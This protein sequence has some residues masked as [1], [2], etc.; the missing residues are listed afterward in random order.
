MDVDK[1]EA[2]ERVVRTIRLDDEQIAKLLDTMDEP[3]GTPATERREAQRYRYRVKALLVHMQQPGSS[4][5][6]PYLVPTRNICESGL[7]FVHGGFV[8]DGTRCLAQL[9]TTYGTWDDV[10]GSV[11]SCGYV[12]ANIHEVSIRFDHHIDPSVYCAA[13]VNYRVLLVEDDPSIARLA[14]FHLVKLNAHVEHVENGKIAVDK[15]MKTAYDVILMDMGLPVMDGFEAVKKLRSEGYSGI[16]V[17]A[18]AL[19]QPGD[20]QRCLEAG[21]DK[22]IAKPF[23]RAD[24]DKLLQVLREEPLISTLY[25]D[26]SM[27]EMIDTYVQELPAKVRTIEQAMVKQ[28]A[29]GLASLVR[30]LKAEGSGYG[31]EIITETAAAIESA[32]ID[33]SSTTDVEE[34]IT[35]LLKLCR[36][37]RS[38]AR[39]TAK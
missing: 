34:D 14:T 35:K 10:W 15:A 9:I 30:T 16:I 37:A 1:A 20:E 31:F 33:G 38:S 4:I 2:T 39:P 7:S 13:A 26:S 24:L 28:D 11:V 5:T 29:E 6:V 12:R 22:Y 3:N 32:L 8:H 27:V 36:Q 23:T 17:A 25:S 19:T 18:T 21:C